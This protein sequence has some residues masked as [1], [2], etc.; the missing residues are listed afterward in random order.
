VAHDT[1]NQAGSAATLC[2]VYKRKVPTASSNVE[3]E[4][5]AENICSY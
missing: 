1:A 5:K 3:F 2:F 4:S